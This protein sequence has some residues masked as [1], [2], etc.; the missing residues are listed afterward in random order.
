MKKHIIYIIAIMICSI[1]ITSCKKEVSP[2]KT[3][4]KIGH[5]LW[6]FGVFGGKSDYTFSYSPN[7]QLIF[8]N[9]YGFLSFNS[10]V[11]DNNAVTSPY[12]FSISTLLNII[13]LDNYKYNGGVNTNPSQN[14]DQQL[15]INPNNTINKTYYVA[16]YPFTPEGSGAGFKHF[17]YENSNLKAIYFDNTTGYGKRID[18]IRDFVFSG[19]NLTAFKYYSVYDSTQFQLGYQTTMPDTSVINVN[20]INNIILCI[21]FEVQEVLPILAVDSRFSLTGKKMER[22]INSYSFTEPNNGNPITTTWLVNYLYDGE[23]HITRINFLDS[24]TA[25][26]QRYVQIDYL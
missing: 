1:M 9:Q 17:T 2:T 21:P 10:I 8:V 14:N 7:N 4:I 26:V 20:G 25:V 12:Q 22:L 13:T 19:K 23:G 3:N 18:T 11:G 24:Q 5:I 6:N 15:F 16:G